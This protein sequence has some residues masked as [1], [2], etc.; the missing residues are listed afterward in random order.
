MYD[1]STVFDNGQT[2][3]A[4]IFFVI[5]STYISLVRVQYKP[6][7]PIAVP[8][9]R[10]L[11]NRFHILLGVSTKNLRAVVHVHFTRWTVNNGRFLLYIYIYSFTI[12]DRH[13]SANFNQTCLL[14]VL[15]YIDIFDGN[16]SLATG[17]RVKN[18]FFFSY[19]S[20]FV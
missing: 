3:L 8:L 5:R 13:D 6:F 16:R 7:I 9:A 12:N 10:C 20:Y 4:F 19:S 14:M 1:P 11:P 2:F 17:Y 18:I 15:L